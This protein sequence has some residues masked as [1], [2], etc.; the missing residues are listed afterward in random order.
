MFFHDILLFHTYSKSI[1]SHTKSVETVMIPF[2]CNKSHNWRLCGSW[3]YGHSEGFK[4]FVSSII[5]SQVKEVQSA[6]D[7]LCSSR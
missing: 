4:R 3:Q 1:C 2:S 6:N 7:S 5:T